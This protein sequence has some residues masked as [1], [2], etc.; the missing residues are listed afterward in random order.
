M[1][2][3]FRG[4]MYHNLAW[5]CV[6][7][8]FLFFFFPEKWE[9]FLSLPLYS[10]HVHP[11]NCFD[12]GISKR[13][14]HHHLHRNASWS[15]EKSSTCRQ[16]AMVASN[17]HTIRSSGSGHFWP[18]TQSLPPNLNFL[19]LMVIIIQLNLS[20][21]VVYKEDKLDNNFLSKFDHWQLVMLN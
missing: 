2:H 20:S 17:R 7:I 3:K 10:C 9:L 13:H 8:L 1:G 15:L 6:P 5:P 19:K 12:F 18:R 11:K 16:R 21:F 14:C 4:A